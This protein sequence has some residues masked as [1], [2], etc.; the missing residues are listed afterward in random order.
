MLSTLNGSTRLYLILGDPIAQVKSPQGVTEAL[1]QRGLNAILAPLHVSPEHLSRFISGAQLAHNLDGLI[2]TIPHKFAAYPHCTTASKRAHFLGATNVMRR[3]TPSGGWQGDQVDGLAFVTALKK[4]GFDPQGCRAL[5]AGAGGAGSAIAEALVSAGVVRL[6]IHDNNYKRRDKLVER[7][8]SMNQA[9][10]AIGSDDPSGFDLVVNATPCGM[11]HGD[12]LPFLADHLHADTV[13]G[14]V[15]TAPE[16]TRW[17]GAA[18]ERGCSTIRGLDMFAEVCT[19]MVDFLL[20]EDSPEQ[21][22]SQPQD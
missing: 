6:A 10:V 7:I 20:E 4:K 5:L 13:V 15:V 18:I 22:K 16:T 3:S 11:T 9:Q 8:A 2:V 1:Q 19:L 12:P 17:I 21:T 14:D